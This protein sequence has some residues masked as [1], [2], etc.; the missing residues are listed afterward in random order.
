MN[1]MGMNAAN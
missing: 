1:R